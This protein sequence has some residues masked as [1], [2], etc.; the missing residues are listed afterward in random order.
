MND[1]NFNTTHYTLFR[2]GLMSYISII[3]DELKYTADMTYDV[4]PDDRS[5]IVFVGG[6]GI[7]ADMD[8]D[9]RGNVTFCELSRTKMAGGFEGREAWEPG[10]YDKYRPTEGL[11][12]TLHADTV[13]MLL[14]ELAEA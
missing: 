13:W 8:L 7:I 3:M 4:S 14:G 6:R 9:T 12:R 1:L 10:P 11:L 2:K 5:L